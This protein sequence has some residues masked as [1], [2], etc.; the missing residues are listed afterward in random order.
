MYPQQVST[1]TQSGSP[2]YFIYLKSGT[3]RPIKVPTGEAPLAVWR[4]GR[5][6]PVFC[7]ATDAEFFRDHPV[8]RFRLAV[9]PSKIYRDFFTFKITTREPEVY[10]D[11]DAGDVRYYD[12][13]QGTPREW[14][15]AE[16][17]RM[18]AHPHRCSDPERWLATRAH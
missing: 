16:C 11:G 9:R 1:A 14:L 18:L 4:Y 10:A 12:A 17:E 2:R 8:A 7:G 6:C 3:L 13:N 5:W 15:L